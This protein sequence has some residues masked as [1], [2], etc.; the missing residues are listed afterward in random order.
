M[1]RRRF[2]ATTVGGAA[3]WGSPGLRRA[4]AQPAAVTFASAVGSAGLVTQVVRRLELDKKHDVR[5]DFKLPAPAAEKAVLLKQVDAGIF[6]VVTAADVNLKDQPVMHTFVVVWR[7]SPYQK[8]AD[9]KGHRIGLL[10]K[11]SGVYRGMQILTARRPRRC[12]RAMR[13][14]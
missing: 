6:P 2:L 1:N 5:V 7:D 3:V 9:L 12:I 4:V 11:V 8:L 13:L 14:T 10:D